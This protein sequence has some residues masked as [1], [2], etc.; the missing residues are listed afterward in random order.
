LVELDRIIGRPV[1]GALTGTDIRHIVVVPDRR[2]AAMPLSAL[3]SWRKYGVS[4]TPSLG[5]YSIH[6]KNENMN[7]S[8]DFRVITNPTGDLACSAIA[9]DAVAKLG[10][11]TALKGPDASAD[12]ILRLLDEHTD[13]NKIEW[14]ISSHG[15]YNVF[16]PLDS[17]LMAADRLI[18][19]RELL[20][21]QVSNVQ[22]AVLSACETLLTSPG[23]G[24]EDLTTLPAILGAAGVRRVLGS[25]WRV[26]E[27]ATALLISRFYEERAN[28]ASPVAALRLAQDWL[29]HLSAPD[30]RDAIK[31][32]A[33]E[34]SDRVQGSA[35][36]M[37]SEPLVGA[38]PTSRESIHPF[39][40]PFYWAGF[41]MFE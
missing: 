4:I 38:S 25:L 9:A 31:K 39:E 13:S 5:I 10:P 6:Q 16:D 15:N 22:L 28:G 20:G 30:A 3:S 35:C 21:M 23:E 11:V 36:A 1:E 29:R 32:L 34:T 27:V 8:T 24:H 19:L 40:D 33:S 18:K 7:G 14:H 12:A 2:L 17:G 37:L 41:A 26:D